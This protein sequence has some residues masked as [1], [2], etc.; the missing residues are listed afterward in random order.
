MR[1]LLR[2]LA[3]SLLV[4]LALAL[5]A[6]KAWLELDGPY[7]EALP[8]Y[9]YCTAAATA[10]QE[11]RYLDALE[12]AEAGGGGAELAEARAAWDGLAARFERCVSGAW[13]GRGEDAFGIGCAVASD[14]VVFGDVRDLTRE[15]LAWLRGEEPDEVLMALSAAGIALTFTPQIGAGASLFKAARRAGALGDGFARSLVK[16]ARDRAW[17]PLSGMLTDAGRLSLELGPARATRALAYADDADELARLARFVDMAP[18]PLLALKW[19]GKG[20]VRLATDDALYREALKRGPAGL[21]LA[22]ARGGRALLARQP[23]VVF[24]AKSLYQHPEALA[25]ALAAIVAFVLRWLT[26]PWVAGAALAL[27]LLGLALRASAR[28]RR[29]ARRRRQGAPERA[30]LR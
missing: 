1:R 8:L 30:R 4:L 25:A 12:L 23:L 6:G 3:G 16:L 10:L 21:E 15:G 19:G 7:L 2:R 18:Q 9:P 5:V 22:A 14:L 24:A 28:Q 11:E 20:A 26:W 17:R 27:A 13:S 29:G